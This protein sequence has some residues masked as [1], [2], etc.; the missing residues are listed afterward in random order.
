MVLNLGHKQV[1]ENARVRVVRIRIRFR[2]FHASVK[3][4]AAIR[5]FLSP[6]SRLDGVPFSSSDRIRIR[7]VLFCRDAAHRQNPGRLPIFL[8]TRRKHRCLRVL[9]LPIFLPV[10]PLPIEAGCNRSFHASKCHS[11]ALAPKNLFEKGC[12]GFF[13]PLR[14]DL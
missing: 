2:G 14:I 9:P 6:S 8:R 4:I 3:T 12:K 1:R 13:A 11:E 10:A 7:S 5:F